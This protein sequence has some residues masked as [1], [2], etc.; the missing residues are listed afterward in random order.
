MRSG[1]SYG[2]I[3]AALIIAGTSSPAR[4]DHPSIGGGPATSGPII[5]MSAVP[6]P[7]GSI[8]AGIR[9]GYFEPDRLSDDELTSRA[10]D[11]IHAHGGDYMLSAAIGAGYGL[12]DEITI[13]F[14][15]PYLKRAELREGEHGHGPGGGAVNSVVEL[16]SS[17]GIG[18]LSLL[19]Q[20]RFAHSDEGNWLAAIVAG[21]KVPIGATHERNRQ[22]E[23]FETE[24]Q[25]GTGSLDPLLGVAFTKGLGSASLDASLLYQISTEGAQATELGDRLQ[26]NLALTYRLD[27]GEVPHGHDGEAEAPHGHSAWDLILELNGEREGRQKIAGDSDPHSG[28]NIIYLSPGIRHVSASGWSAAVSVGI[29]IEQRIRLSHP[30]QAWR[31]TAAISRSF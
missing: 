12:T 24:H 26:Y 31:M 30:E 8:A 28:G 27:G 22:G 3:C 13:G 18:D 16:G 5:T 11:H 6:M 25:P 4:A 2:T 14:S 10:G 29:P 21:V 1:I 9:L 15:L 7:K 23:R 17:E 19:G 20:Y